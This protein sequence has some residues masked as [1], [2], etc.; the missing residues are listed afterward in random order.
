MSSSGERVLLTSSPDLERFKRL[1]L[2][3]T[4]GS[5]HEVLGSDIGPKDG[6]PEP[7][8]VSVEAFEVARDI[9]SNSLPSLVG[10]CTTRARPVQNR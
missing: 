4:G 5:A 10:L 2:Q 7:V 6:E 9:S 3:R 8:V 1:R